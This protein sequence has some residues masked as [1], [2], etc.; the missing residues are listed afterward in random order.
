MKRIL[1]SR[2]AL[3]A[4]RCML[5]LLLAAAVS[6]HAAERGMMEVKVMRDRA[7]MDFTGGGERGRWR[8]VNDGVMG[9]LSRSEFLDDGDGP[10]VFRGTVSLDN[11]GGFA[12]VRTAPADLGLGGFDGIRLQVRGDGKRYSFRL[13][14]DDRF[15]GVAWSAPFE[16]RAGEWVTVT[17]PFDE[18]RPTWRGRTVPGT[19]PLDPARIRQLGLLIADRQ[20]GPFRID[21]G[22]ISG[23]SAERGE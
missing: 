9:G 15:D 8:V 19:P 2:P 16:T 7:I 6:G 20:A 22:R 10:G 12:S 11:N 18:F 4:Q 3:A 17:L 23:Y 5:F 21:I 1:D 13:R 14:T